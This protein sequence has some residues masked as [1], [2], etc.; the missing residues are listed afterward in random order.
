VLVVDDDAG[1]RL[2]FARWL[3]N[4]GFEVAEAS[5]GATALKLLR[6]ASFDILVLDSRMPRMNGRETLAR[7]RADLRNHSLPVL[8]VTS[9]TELSRR[10]HGFMDG[11]DDFLIKPVDANQLTGR[12]HALLQRG[13]GAESIQRLI[14]TAHDAFLA[15]DSAGAILEWNSQAEA[16]FGWTKTE[17]LTHDAATMIITPASRQA[18]TRAVSRSVATSDQPAIVER[19]E[20]VGILRDGSEIPIEMTVWAVRVGDTYTLSAL[21]RSSAARR[22][23]ECSLRT[24]ERL[25]AL[26]E[27]TPDICTLT[28]VDGAILYVSP[29]CRSLGYEPAAMIGRFGHEFVHPQDILAHAEMQTAA[30]GHEG[31]TTR[32]LRVR[33]ESGHYLWM[34]TTACA[35]RATTSGELTGIQ[36]IARDATQRHATEVARE[37]RLAELGAANRGLEEALA[38]ERTTVRELGD[39]LK[40]K[41]EFVAMVSHELRTP[42]TSI[43]G[44]AEM[45]DDGEL[46]ELQ[47]DQH[48]VLIIMDQNARRLVALVEDLLT[49]G[50]IEA[51][52]FETQRQPLDL[53]PIIEAAGMT[54]LPSARSKNVVLHLDVDS[55][56][57]VVSADAAQ[58]DRLLLNLLSNAVKFTPPGGRVELTARSDFDGVIL[59]VTDDGIGIPAAEQNQVFSRFFRARRT[60]EEEVPGTGLGL[61][62]V[63][64]IV[65]QHHG[66]ISLVS[67]PGTGTTVSVMLP[68]ALDP[69]C[70]RDARP[71][72]ERQ[73]AT[74]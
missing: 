34:D 16:I 47:D 63:K 61:A 65:E 31:T 18:F 51:G 39:L 67:E 69:E 23:L 54:V 13:T 37:Q 68:R 19:V 60:V 17:T 66:Q 2:L 35:V 48:R 29:S 36:T 32:Q 28:D 25:Q 52:S 38:G 1:T 26:M 57:G 7:L 49:I 64:S 5:D 10:A 20:L 33:A 21:V 6:H 74:T 71:D 27:S 72:R 41:D 8:L 42:L 59:D 14:E 43:V 30:L 15:W 11:A 62:I 44:Y 55:S 4:A 46:G 53:G 40:L 3:E 24:S 56:L 22:E 9:D 50:R 73:P 58:L 12:I 70:S 45:L